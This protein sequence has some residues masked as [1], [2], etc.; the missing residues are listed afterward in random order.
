MEKLEQLE[1][2]GDAGSAPDAPEL[3]AFDAKDIARHHADAHWRL[4]RNGSV[5][6]RCSLWWTGVPVLPG[7]TIGCVGHFAALDEPSSVRLLDHAC[8]ELAGRGCTLAIGPMDGNTWRRY[9]FLTHRGTEPPFFL[10]PDNPDE[11]PGYFLAA[12]FN[13]MARYFSALCADLACTDPRLQR[14]SPRMDHAGVTTRTIDPGRLEGELRAI[15][16]LCLISFRDNYLYTPLPE[17]EFIAQYRP[18]LPLVRPE[19]IQKAL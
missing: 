15:H 12:G 9:R 16:A 13:P 10:E 7:E 4:V 18:I 2:P 6:A 8:K 19:L 14:V 17:E 5:A 1:S 11:W 3:P